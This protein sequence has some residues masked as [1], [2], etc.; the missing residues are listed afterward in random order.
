MLPR[1]A[2]EVQGVDLASC[3]RVRMVGIEGAGI[4][5]WR[6]RLTARIGGIEFPLSFLVSERADTPYLLGRLDFF[7]AFSIEIDNRSHVLRL[8]L[9][10]GVA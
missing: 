4:Q 6:T 7:S 8:H 2:A 1:T 10:E 3:P 9:L 5:A